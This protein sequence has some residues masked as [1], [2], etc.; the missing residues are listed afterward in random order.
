MSPASRALA[1]SVA[2]TAPSRSAEATATAATRRCRRLGSGTFIAQAAAVTVSKRS[3]YGP[4]V[5]LANV[6]VFSVSE[7]PE[8]T[9]RPT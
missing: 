9:A 5:I 3:A 2:A 4:T 1:A 6:A 8:A 7:L